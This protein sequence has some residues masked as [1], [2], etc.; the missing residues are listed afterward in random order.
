MD[1]CYGWGALCARFQGLFKCPGGQV[2][3]AEE[4]IELDNMNANNAAVNNNQG[5]TV[6]VRIKC[7]NDM[8]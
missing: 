5:Q 2:A 1:D 7:D 6:P 8:I 4:D 3:P